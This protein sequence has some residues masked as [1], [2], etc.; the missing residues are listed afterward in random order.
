MCQATGYRTTTVYPVLDRLL[1]AGW[2]N[3]YWEDPPPADPP[4][5]RF[6]EITSIGREQYAAVL[7]T[8]SERRVVWL[9]PNPQPGAIP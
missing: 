2:I 1:K 9:R 8:H 6:Y 3:G 7:R 4:R 5:R